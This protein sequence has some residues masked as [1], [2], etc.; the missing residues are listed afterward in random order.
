MAMMTSTPKQHSVV[1]QQDLMRLGRDSNHYVHV[2]CAKEKIY[3]HI[4]EFMSSMTE[5]DK[6]IPMFSGVVLTVN[7]WRKLMAYAGMIDNHIQMLKTKHLDSYFVDDVVPIYLTDKDDLFVTAL[8][9]K[10]VIKVRITFEITLSE[11]EWCAI[12]AKSLCVQLKVTDLER[13]LNN[14]IDAQ[15]DALCLQFETLTIK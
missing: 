12:K 8:M 9:Y 1:L 3:I 2:K 6:M 10:G 4:C 5:D 11:Q 14:T 15:I 7:Q 13:K